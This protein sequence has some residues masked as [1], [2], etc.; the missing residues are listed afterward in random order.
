VN[1]RIAL[2]GEDPRQAQDLIERGLAAIDGIE[3]PVAA[4]QVHATAAEVFQ[5]LRESDRARSHRESS[6][7]TIL[8]LAASLDTYE[9]S[10]RT[11]LTSPAIVR[12]L[13]PAAAGSGRLSPARS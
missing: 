2:A 5:A 10:R 11:F 12:V 3:V 8:R 4:W 1:A 7:D 9:A 13:D 6:R